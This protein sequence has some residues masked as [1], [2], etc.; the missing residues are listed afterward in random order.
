[1][2]IIEGIY[3]QKI[4]SIIASV[5]ASDKKIKSLSEQ[6][7]D[8]VAHPLSGLGLLE[9]AV[10][11]IAA[12]EGRVI[13]DISRKAVAVFCADNGIVA[14][15]VSQTGQEV[16]AIVAENMCTGKTSVCTMAKIARATVFPVDAGLLRAITHK[17]MNCICVRRGTADFLKED[18]MTREEACQT[19]LRGAFFAK[20]LV[21][22]GFSLLATGEMGIGNTTTSTAVVC[23]LLSLSVEAVTGRGAGLTNAGL[24]TKIRVIRE[25]LE[26]RNPDKSD[27]IDVLCKVGGLDIAAMTGFFVGAAAEKTPVLIDGFISAVSALLAARLC[28]HCADFFLATHSSSEPAVKK[29]FSALKKRPFISAQMHLGE[30]TGAVAAMPLLDMALSV[31]KTMATFNDI[32]VEAY[33]R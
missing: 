8:S 17:K 2:S 16:S 14:E 15:G 31:Y 1:M 3:E 24:Q 7:W 10:S 25:G 27:P 19:F 23:A 29:V 26:R 22:K 32:Q 18:A 20:T 28:P 21:Q 6:R 33:K 4:K 13:P 5:S 12:A 9:N 11:S 30:G